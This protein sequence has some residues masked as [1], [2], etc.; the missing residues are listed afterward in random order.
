LSSPYI[1][2]I[3]PTLDEERNMRPLLKTIARALSGYEYD[4]IVVDG[5]SQD[6]TVE[7]AQR[8]GTRILRE[9][10]GKGAAL[11]AGFSA[12][13]GDITIAIDADLSQRPS[14]LIRFVRGM[15]E[16]YDVCLGS[17]FMAGAKS[18]DLTAVRAVGN[19]LLCWLVNL[20]I[21]SRY[22]D[23]C[24][25]YMG[26]KR[27]VFG[28]LDLKEAGFGIEAEVHIKAFKKKLKIL[29]V[30][31]TEK[32]RKFGDAKLRTFHDGYAVLRTIISNSF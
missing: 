27:S 26:F 5:G 7:I 6:K 2:V 14:E 20:R 15:E 29:E 32:R 19:K 31:S 25:G 24:Y 10:S 9:T 16:G 18:Y 3:I 13:R 17:R 23:L 22:T 11:R 21:G 1:S 12:A 28:E 8:F 4:V 30:P